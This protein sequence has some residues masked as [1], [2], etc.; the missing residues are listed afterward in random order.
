MYDVH[1]KTNKSYIHL[2]MYTADRH[3][4]VHCTLLTLVLVVTQITVYPDSNQIKQ[5]TDI[6]DIQFK[7]KLFI[8]LAYQVLPFFK[9]RYVKY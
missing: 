1:V 4:H 2:Y 3:V 8:P 7:N 6:M 9:Y 5:S